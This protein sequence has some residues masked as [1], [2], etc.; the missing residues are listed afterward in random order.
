MVDPRKRP[1]AVAA[2]Q[3]VW[4]PSECRGG[5]AEG[6][7]EKQSDIVDEAQPA[8]GRHAAGRPV[9]VEPGKALRPRPR[10]VA[11]ELD[12]RGPFFVGFAQG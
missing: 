6:V 1:V 12:D 3:I 9:R 4:S 5:G 2:E 7:I 11:V 8:P 10:D